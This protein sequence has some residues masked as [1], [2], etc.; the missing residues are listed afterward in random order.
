M[1]ET[2][3]PKIDRAIQDK[4]G[5][6][7][8]EM[9]EAL[10]KQPLRGRL[11]APLRAIDEVEASRQRLKETLVA[12]RSRSPAASNVTPFPKATSA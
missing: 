1:A 4:I 12:M 7:L 5:R 10:L 8:R 3:K 11:T 9:Y 2:Q 6:E